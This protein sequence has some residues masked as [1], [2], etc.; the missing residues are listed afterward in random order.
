VKGDLNLQK[1]PK[2][3]AIPKKSTKEKDNCDVLC[4]LPSIWC[5][6]NLLKI[7]NFKN[8]KKTMEQ[9]EGRRE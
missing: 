1:M 9:K 6:K 2:P 5:N 7:K 3:I 8:F 4:L